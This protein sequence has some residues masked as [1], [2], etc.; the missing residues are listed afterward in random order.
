MRTG[1]EIGGN[2][3]AELYQ[4][5]LLR[6]GG[7]TCMHA[8]TH[9]HTYARLYTV[10]SHRGQK[11]EENGV[12]AAS[13]T[14]I[15]FEISTNSS[16]CVYLEFFE[17]EENVRWKTT[18]FDARPCYLTKLRYDRRQWRRPR[19]E[20]PRYYLRAC[21]L[22]N[23]DQNPL[24][25]LTFTCNFICQILDGSSLIIITRE[26]GTVGNEFF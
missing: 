4:N 2:S 12:V 9:T 1:K 17:H 11:E 19:Y 26:R 24:N 3:S 23:R 7:H 20:K 10:E 21:H 5:K 16:Y 14:R 15:R 22:T 8:H 6:V 18:L 25:D 13:Y